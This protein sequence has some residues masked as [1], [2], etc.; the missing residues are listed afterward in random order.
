LK[1]IGRLITVAALAGGG[2]YI[3]SMMNIVQNFEYF[4]T[5]LSLKKFTTSSA[6]INANLVIKNKGWFSVTINR[7]IVDVFIDQNYVGKIIKNEAFI[8]KP[9]QDSVIP[10]IAAIDPKLIGSNLISILQNINFSEEGGKFDNLNFKF[11]GNIETK[12]VGFKVN[13]PFSYSQLYKN[14]K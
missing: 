9:S 11:V 12:I 14:F 3:Y 5:N 7:L 10:I 13:L 2:A 8:V 6:E 4:V 1:L